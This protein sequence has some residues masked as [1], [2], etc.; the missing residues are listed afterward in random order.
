MEPGSCLWHPHEVLC[1]VSRAREGG[2]VQVGDRPLPSLRVRFLSCPGE[3]VQQETGRLLDSAFSNISVANYTL[4]R[5]ETRVDKGALVAG[6]A[7][8]RRRAG[9]RA[10]AKAVRTDADGDGGRAGGHADNMIKSVGN[11]AT[12]WLQL[13]RP[14]CRRRAADSR[15][16][17]GR[18]FSCSEWSLR[19]PH[20]RNRCPVA[21]FGSSQKE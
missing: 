8:R 9:G 10:A 2:D 20:Y 14:V 19:S 12:K 5:A 16:R 17:C 18:Q 6:H 7:S 11:A 21:L 13:C 4:G 1:A 3:V 15:G